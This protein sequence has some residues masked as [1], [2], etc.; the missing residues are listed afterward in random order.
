M[1]AR[2]P[3]KGFAWVLPCLL[4]ALICIFK[5]KGSD[6]LS[7]PKYAFHIDGGSTQDLHDSEQ[8]DRD[9]AA[10][11]RP[12]ARYQGVSNVQ[13]TPAA[14]QRGVTIVLTSANRLDLL[15]KTLESFRQY[16]T[17]PI[18]QGILIEDSG[19]Q[20][21]VD[22]AH[23]L[24]DFPLKIIYN[25]DLGSKRKHKVGMLGLL[26]SVDKAY[27]YVTTEFIF[28]MEDDWLFYQSGFIERS[29]DI[30]DTDPALL[31]VWLRAHNDGHSRGPG[32]FRTGQNQSYYWMALDYLTWHGFSFNPGLKRLQDYQD[33]GGSYMAATMPITKDAFPGEHD[34]STLYY[35]LGYKAAITDVKDGFVSHLGWNR[36]TDPTSQFEGGDSTHN[37]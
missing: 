33:I 3:W 18:T 15:Q 19:I 34:I 8:G 20:G 6:D 1:S 16:N 24:V 28:H 4:W 30:L 29:I 5:K 7:S 13:T 10:V 23:D 27:S 12:F 9:S 14:Q 36:S 22:F 32:P 25:P 17:Y 26:E 31:Q 11:G 21:N 37:A 35:N 2:G